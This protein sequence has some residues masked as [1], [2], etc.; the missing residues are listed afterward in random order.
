MQI[1]ALFP[2]KKLKTQNQKTNQIKVSK[3]ILIHN[4]FLT[5]LQSDGGR[6]I[7]MLAN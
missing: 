1:V 5:S 2:A 6:V 7:C 4:I 3:I